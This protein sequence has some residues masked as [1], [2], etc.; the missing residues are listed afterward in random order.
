MK[1][2]MFD[3][4][5]PLETFLRQFEVCARYNGWSGSDKGAFVQCSREKG[6]T[7]LLWDFGAKDHVTYRELV[8]RLRQRYGLEAQQETFRAQLR[9]RRQR[10]RIVLQ[11]CYTT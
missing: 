10:E 3:G 5:I 7:Q 6:P 8:E 4:S 11:T 1:H 2:N 9:C